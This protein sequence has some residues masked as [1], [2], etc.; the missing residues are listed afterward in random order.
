MMRY[1]SLADMPSG[2]QRK[3]APKLLEAS[4]TKI[5]AT[6]ENGS[7]MR[8]G[9]WFESMAA[10]DRYITLCNLEQA[11]IIK[12]LRIRDNVTLVDKCIYPGGQKRCQVRFHA[13]FSYLPQNPAFYP[14]E[15][16]TEETAYME[17]CFFTCPEQRV[18]EVMHVINPEAREEARN[19]GM[20]IREVMA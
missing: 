18:Y 17:E 6:S 15:I 7:V 9:I 11:G 1:E 19:R 3:A 14:P 8:D 12:D 13:D 2:M 10:A 5:Q 20:I 16:R 4:R